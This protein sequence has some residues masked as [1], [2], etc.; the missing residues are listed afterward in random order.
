MHFVHSWTRKFTHL[1]GFDVTMPIEIVAPYFEDLKRGQVFNAPGVTITAGHTALYQALFGDRMQLPLDHHLSIEVAGCERPLVHPGLVSNIA[2]GQSTFPS[3]RVKGNLFYR[4]LVY[5]RPVWLG[6]TLRT[7]TEVIAL[8]QNQDKPGR[9]ATGVA[10]LEVTVKDQN[11]QL[12]M[13]FWRC[14]MLP[15]RDAKAKTG[16][17]DELAA[18]PELIPDS[19]I[20]AAVPTGWNTEPLLERAEG[21]AFKEVSEGSRYNIEA[22]DTVT[23]APELVRATLNMAMSHTDAQASYLGKRLVYGGHTIGMALAQITRALPTICTLVGWES[24]D[25]TAPVLEGDVIQSHFTILRKF[26]NQ[27]G[28]GICKLHAES[29]ASRFTAGVEES[30]KVLDWKFFAMLG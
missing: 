26:S 24:C 7:R 23:S 5:L 2:I 13:K 12:V 16:C 20:L 9:S 11:D 14:P 25:H 6:D 4:G 15:C 28:A 8:R 19:Q 29:Y 30:T 1:K 21:P 17:A 27:T 3:Q 18:I 22:R 10:A